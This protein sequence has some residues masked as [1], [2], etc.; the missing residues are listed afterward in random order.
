M[1]DNLEPDQLDGDDEDALTL[2]AYMAAPIN[3]KNQTLQP[4]PIQVQHGVVESTQ[5]PVG[6][7]TFM[8]PAGEFTLM[9]QDPQ[10]IDGLLAQ[11]AQVKDDLV[12]ANLRYQLQHPG[13]GQILIPT[14]NVPGAN[15]A[16]LL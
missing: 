14:P 16:K 8:H 6:A 13:A 5:G 1:T 11:L 10:I 2:Q 15:G 7:V 9:V 3:P 12:K 4:V